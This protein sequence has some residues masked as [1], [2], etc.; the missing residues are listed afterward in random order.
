M[1]HRHKE[2]LADCSKDL[3]SGSKLFLMKI[4]LRVALV[5][6]SFHENPSA[7]I[8]LPPSFS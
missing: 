3:L 8:H 6:I 2:N 1:P 7:G 4:G 5:T